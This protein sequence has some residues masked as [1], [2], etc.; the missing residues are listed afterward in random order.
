MRI[1]TVFS[2]LPRQQKL[3]I[4]RIVHFV[5]L[6]HIYYLYSHLA[7]HSCRDLPES[8]LDIHED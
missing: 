8:C 2:I 5:H 7:Q 3:N 6:V 4:L 1:E